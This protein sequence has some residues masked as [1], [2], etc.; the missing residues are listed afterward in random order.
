MCTTETPSQHPYISVKEKSLFER[1]GVTTVTIN[2]ATI[3]WKLI[4]TNPPFIALCTAQVAWGWIWSNMVLSIP[5][6]FNNLFHVDL[7]SNG[8]YTS[9]PFIYAMLFS[10][11]VGYT[12]ELLSNREIV[13]KKYLRKL[14]NTVSLGGTSI[15]LLA[16][17]YMQS[18]MELTIAVLCVAAGL[19]E[20]NRCA[21]SINI[22]DIAPNFSGPLMSIIMACATISNFGQPMLLGWFTNASAGV[23]QYRK[24]FLVLIAFSFIGIVSFGVWG[25]TVH[26][27]WDKQGAEIEEV[28]G[29]LDTENETKRIE[30]NTILQEVE[31]H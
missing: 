2:Q 16:T 6:F 23:E 5:K 8:L 30:L 26:Q 21:I 1:E 31:Q 18:K 17:T 7:E 11:I 28:E 27:A 14:I 12:C 4:L 25:S 22:L 9:F 15:L 10:N 24:Y 29:L 13:S 19:S 20:M 3:P